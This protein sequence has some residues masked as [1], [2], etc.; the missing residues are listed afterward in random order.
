MDTGTGSIF[1]L[2]GMGAAYLPTIN[3][4]FLTQLKSNLIHLILPIVLGIARP[5]SIEFFNYPHNV[6]EYG[7]HWNFFLTIAVVSL[8]SLFISY[9]LSKHL[10]YL[11]IIIMLIYEFILKLGLQDYIINIHRT[12]FISEN[13]EGI[14]Q[15]I[16]YTVCYMLGKDFGHQIKAI[17]VSTKNNPLRVLR[18][19]VLTYLHNFA[20]LF[21][22]IYILKSEPSRRMAN[23]SY[24]W[25]TY[26][27]FYT[28]L[29]SYAFYYYLCVDPVFNTF[30]L[31]IHNNK[32]FYFLAAN[33]MVG[34][35]NLTFN[36][37]SYSDNQ[38]III[39]SIYCA[40]AFTLTRL[41]DILMPIIF[42][43]KSTIK[44]K[45]N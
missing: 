18:S 10:F 45:E 12:N 44:K 5:I 34:S 31:S 23:F 11:S 33:L 14:V 22:S 13:I 15:C 16:G 26:I 41:K 21:L 7:V 8:F 28:A 17:Q 4:P 35:F 40:F 39:L 27:L 37:L 43:K 3:K 32:L 2:M 24:V 19:Y 30:I 29:I 6:N 9:I 20:I 36:S 42:K 1:M 38:A 25:M